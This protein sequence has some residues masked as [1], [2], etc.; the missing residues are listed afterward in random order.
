MTLSRQFSS[1]L[2]IC[3][4]VVGLA[5]LLLGAG[6]SRAQPEPLST[7][8]EVLAL[9]PSRAQARL[10]VTVR[11]VVTAA[12]PAWNGQFFVQDDTA[13]IFV[14]ARDAPA[15]PPGSHVEIRGFTHP[16]DFAPIIG[17]PTVQRLGLAP[18][19]PARPVETT[20]LMTGAEDCQRIAVNGLVRRVTSEG[21]QWRLIVAVDGYRLTAFVPALPFAPPAEL[22]GARLHLQG[23]AAT[24]YHSPVRQLLDVRLHVPRLADVELLASSDQDPW[25]LPPLPLSS[26][27]QYR[28]QHADSNRVH[29]TGQLTL[30][31][32]DG[33]AFLQD[34]SGGLR[35]DPVESALPAVGTTVEAVGFVEFDNYLP[36]LRDAVLRPSATAL[37]PPSSITP[38]F[39]E[40][41]QGLHHGERLRLR[42]RLLDV[43]TRPL[44]G[45]DA[46]ETSWLLQTDDLTATVD[47]V[48][49]PDQTASLRTALPLGAHVQIDGVAQSSLDAAG[50][51]VALHLHLATATDAA[52]LAPP[53]WWTPA[54]LFAALGGTVCALLL[55]LVWSV[56]HARQNARL[57]DLLNEV[58]RARAA[59]ND[60]NSQLESKVA[61]RTAQLE[62]EITA[63]K[64]DELQFKGAL[65]ERTRL[66]RELH[67]SL[68]QTLTGVNLRLKTAATLAPRDPSAAA[69]HLQ[70]AQQLLQQ[71]QVDLRRSIW[72]LRSRELEQFDLA[73]ALRR[74]AQHLAEASGLTWTFDSEYPAPR[75]PEVVEENVL[76]IGQEAL[77]NIAK[78]AQAH[79]VQLRL[80]ATPTTLTLEICDNGIG[81]APRPLTELGQSG[82]FGLI[83]MQE[84]ARRIEATFTVQPGPSDRGTCIRLVVPRP[85]APPSS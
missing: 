19:P 11:G 34:A 51:L 52:V 48:H 80:Q 17:E 75:W 18:L 83:G 55:V 22:V 62:V 42:G 72:D 74:N 6:L 69:H 73:D 46:V 29:V 66:A 36:I 50:Q 35:V 58:E 70:T 26:I 32:P 47:L 45:T 59:L 82:H 39:D 85:P 71:S 41:R 54:R 67:D 21:E 37:S 8:A 14:D 43:S 23:T 76:R 12:D 84:R 15:P 57:R 27:A 20:R 25:S 79:A 24:T 9:S 13:G 33:I 2:R 5:W 16:G 78:H 31:R 10:P 1:R 38:P 56:H 4:C 40:L 60:I 63:R 65:T 3:R 7:A 68:E 30:D 44:A 49:A 61:E 53:A 81:F 28:P 77:T 64:A